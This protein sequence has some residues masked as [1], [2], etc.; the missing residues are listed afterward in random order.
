MDLLPVS[1]EQLSRGQKRPNSSVQ[2]L[3]PQQLID[4]AIESHITHLSKKPLEQN[5]PFFIADLGQVTR[6]HQR[7]KQN[8]PQVHP[9]YGKL[10][11]QT[12][13]SSS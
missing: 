11:Q 9:Y 2:D 5:E 6:Q 8:L 3:L 10:P 13:S 1:R 7:W 4:L 12:H